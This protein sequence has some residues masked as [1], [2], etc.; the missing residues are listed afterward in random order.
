MGLKQHPLW[1]VHFEG[2]CKQSHFW[3]TSLAACRHHGDVSKHLSC[4]WLPSCWKGC[5]PQRSCPTCHILAATLLF[6]SLVCLSSLKEDAYNVHRP[7]P[8]RRR[9]SGLV[10]CACHTQ[11]MGHE[12]AGH[13]QLGCWC[14]V[15]KVYLLW[16]LCCDWELCKHLSC[17]SLF[18]KHLYSL[19]SQC[20]S[21][22]QLRG[23]QVSCFSCFL[24]EASL[25]PHI[26][27]L[28]KL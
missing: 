2:A 27:F 12:A 10:T 7:P 17:A 16:Q 25:T 22:Q 14:D 28:L 21:S 6:P 8:L 23:E 1:P 4:R 26:S 3:S 13:G 20:A 18:F 24:L 11:D 19:L 15:E 5:G 9:K